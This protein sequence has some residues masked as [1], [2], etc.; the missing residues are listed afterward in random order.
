MPDLNFISHRASG[1][2][3]NPLKIL[4]Q[5]MPY[6]N[7]A[8]SGMTKNHNHM[9]SNTLHLSHARFRISFPSGIRKILESFKNA[10][11][12]NAHPGSDK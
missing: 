8:R 10:G 1:I 11:S 7:R 5:T 2:S 12:D 6:T 4:V 3:F 9:K